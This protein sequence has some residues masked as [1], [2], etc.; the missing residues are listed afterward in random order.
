M[1]YFYILFFQ[2]TNAYLTNN[3][4]SKIFLSRAKTMMWADWDGLCRVLCKIAA[5]SATI[6]GRAHPRQQIRSLIFWR[7][8][9]QPGQPGLCVVSSELLWI[10][11][12]L[13][14]GPCY[15]HQALGSR[16]G[17]PW[18]GLTTANLSDTRECDWEIGKWRD[19]VLNFHV[20]VEEIKPLKWFRYCYQN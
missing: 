3:G 7:Q 14:P 19:E 5:S 18:L 13:S 6:R 17:Q 4:D 15:N 9:R 2:V 16:G 11:N 20:N 12:I 10:T 1:S 8:T